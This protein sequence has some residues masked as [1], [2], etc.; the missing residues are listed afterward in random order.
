MDRAPESTLATT[1]TSL[2]V[3]ETLQELD[4]AG[5]DE[6]AEELGVATSTAFKHL[7]TLESD[8]YLVKEGGEYHL[9]LK[10]LNL[11]EYARNRRPER[12]LVDEAVQELTDR[13]D[14][15][16]DYIVEEHGRIVT[17]SESYHKWVKYPERDSSYR[18]RVGEYYYMHATATGKSILAEHPRDR[19]EAIIDEWG[20]PARTENTITDREELFEELDRIRERGYAYDME[21]YT[22]GLRSVARVVHRPGAASLASMSVSGPSYRL[23]GEVLREEIPGTLHE[24]VGDLETKIEDVYQ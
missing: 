11:G 6:V 13:T 21:E 14:E 7:A 15:E 9:G 4:G 23:T 22:E 10:F 12:R 18:A 24:V 5:L 16:V 20:L 3:I 2:A 1:A 8:G 19:V 17:V